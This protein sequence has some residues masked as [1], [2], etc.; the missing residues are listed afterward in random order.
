[1]KE[2]LPDVFTWSWRS[3][4][5][6]YDFNGYFVRLPSGNVCIDPVEMSDELLDDLGGRGLACIVL[7]NRNHVR[8]CERLRRKTGAPVFIHPA[9]A[10][11]AEHLGAAID[12]YLE[13]GQA[14]GPLIVHS[15]AGK[16]PGEIC[17]HWPDRKTLFV[18]DACIGAPPG[19]CS[20]LPEKVME[21]PLALQRN[22]KRIASRIDFDA[23][24][25]GDG[26]PIL[27]GGRRALQ[28]LVATFS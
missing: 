28:D 19:Q 21:D 20:L 25:L 26:E 17:L 11:E 6:G 15:A 12:E 3:P 5:L 10:A 16:S 23:L 14:I 4:R 8:A 13:V 24:L 1:M 9:D 22:L 2:I 27:R 7:T 18:G